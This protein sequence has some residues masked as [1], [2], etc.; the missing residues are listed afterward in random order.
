M[1]M[2]VRKQVSVLMRQHEENINR[3]LPRLT[4]FYAGFSHAEAAR[5]RAGAL[6][7]QTASCTLPAGVLQ[8][9]SCLLLGLGKKKSHE[10]RV[11]LC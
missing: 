5:A 11:G 9:R 8:Q 7:C 10:Y 6:S 4:G 1:V 2:F 3:V